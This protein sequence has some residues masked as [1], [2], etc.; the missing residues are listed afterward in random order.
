[1]KNYDRIYLINKVIRSC[2]SC[3]FLFDQSNN[4]KRELMWGESNEILFIGQAPALS[5]IEKK[6]G[7]RFDKF[8]EGLVR[9]SEI[10]F[11]SI[12]FTNISKAAV[13]SGKIL[14]QEQKEHCFDHVSFEVAHLKPRLVITLG[15]LAREWAGLSSF[16]ESDLGV[17]SCEELDGTITTTHVPIF[18][19][20]HPGSIKYHKIT[21]NHIINRLNQA[22]HYGEEL[23][24]DQ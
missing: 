14:S 22:Y 10:P 16:G 19:M 5:N 6:K 13:P 7:S 9:K 8:F 2:T 20:E 3:P 1:M 18:S 23:S 4:G 12:A 11:E 15:T 24:R 21:E 17:F